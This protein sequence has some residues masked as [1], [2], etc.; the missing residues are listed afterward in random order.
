MFSSE[1]VSLVTKS[2]FRLFLFMFS[3]KGINTLH[4]IFT[5]GNDTIGRVSKNVMNWV[6]RWKSE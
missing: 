6:L 2:Q 1:Q 3:F 5:L 4:H